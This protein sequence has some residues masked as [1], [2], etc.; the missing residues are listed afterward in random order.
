[1][2]EAKR[3][4]KQDPNFGQPIAY[5]C[6]IFNANEEQVAESQFMVPRK[7]GIEDTN[8]AAIANAGLIANYFANPTQESARLL[9]KA[10]G[11]GDIDAGWQYVKLFDDW[12]EKNADTAIPDRKFYLRL[13]GEY[14]D[15][16]NAIKGWEEEA[17][18]FGTFSK[19]S[20]SEYAIDPQVYALLAS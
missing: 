2:G 11:W 13:T 17:P 3:R 5:T 14:I 4:E 10:L 1:M 15:Q 16:W 18:E 19:G 7:K 9:A 8:T 12:L 20:R 6:L